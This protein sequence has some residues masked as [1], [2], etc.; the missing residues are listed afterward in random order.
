[1]TDSNQDEPRDGGAGALPDP[2]AASEDVAER[3]VAATGEPEAREAAE[4]LAVRAAAMH[5]AEAIAGT[6][7]VGLLRWTAL[8]FVGALVGLLFGRPDAALFLAIAALFALTQAWDARDRARTGDPLSDA[9]LAPGDVGQVLRLLVPLLAPAGGAAFYLALAVYAGSLTKTAANVAA[10]QWCIAAAAVCLL[11]A[12]RPVAQLVANALLRGTPPSFTARLTASIA[13]VLLLLPVP[14]RLMFDEFMTA[15][16]SS[17]RPLVDIGGLV[18]QLAGEVVFA[19]AAVGLWVARDLR[20]VRDRLGLGRM[21]AR[22]WLVAAVGL[23]AVIGVNS[24]MEWLERE[25]FHDLWL[26]DQAMGKLIVENLSL[27]GA[28]VLGVSAGVGEELVVRGALQ[29]RTGLVWASLLFAAGHAQ[30]TWFG[31]L[32]IL[33]LGLALGLVRNRA[34][35]TT[36]IVVHVLY[37][38]FAVAATP[39]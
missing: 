22:E 38:I 1:M 18:A 11:L 12:F 23:A 7:R 9:V 28:L 15:L 6:A 19:L 20:A 24:G 5:A 27:V 17:G 29:P 14:I 32:T 10:M 4:A 35:T 8:V 30:Y 26:A 33:L 39:A 2:G 13:L 31:M 34:N 3:A 37:D 25:R 16:T 36:A 21:G